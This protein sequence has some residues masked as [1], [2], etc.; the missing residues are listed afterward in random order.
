[1]AK[2]TELRE[3]TD[4]ELIA[5]EAD[6][7][8]EIFELRNSFAKKDKEVKPQSIRDKRKDVAR[9]LTILGQR[10]ASKGM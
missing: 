1:M 2:A 4:E 9:I 5:L 8:K 6:K 10:Q 3:Q 7:R